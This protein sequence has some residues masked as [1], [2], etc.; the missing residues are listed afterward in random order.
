MCRNCS[1]RL[2]DGWTQLL[3][4]DETHR[5]AAVDA[6]TAHGRHES[7][8]DVGRGDDSSRCKSSHT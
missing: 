1:H 6:E 3:S 8:D 5:T 4:Y 2:H 7:R